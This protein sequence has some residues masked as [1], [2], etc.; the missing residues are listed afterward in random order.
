MIIR[1]IG[2]EGDIKEFEI[3]TNSGIKFTPGGIVLSITHS[4]GLYEQK[5]VPYSACVAIDK[6]WEYV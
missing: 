1:C 6:L 5:F 3:N 2:K 4:S